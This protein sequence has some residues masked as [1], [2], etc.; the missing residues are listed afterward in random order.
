[1]DPEKVL[2][3]ARRLGGPPTRA[4]IVGCEPAL[5]PTAPPGEE[6]VAG[7]SPVVERAVTEAIKLVEALVAQLVEPK[8]VVE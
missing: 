2:W 3:L 5:V 4:L 6:V 7:L 1:M 8:G